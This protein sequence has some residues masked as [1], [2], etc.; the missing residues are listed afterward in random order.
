MDSRSSSVMDSARLSGRLLRLKE[1]AKLRRLS[2]DLTAH[3][4]AH[5]RHSRVGDERRLTCAKEVLC[6]LRRADSG[7]SQVLQALRKRTPSNR[8]V[9]ERKAL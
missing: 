3:R 1:A 8:Y 9:E 6:L 2:P 5:T 4:V 7:R